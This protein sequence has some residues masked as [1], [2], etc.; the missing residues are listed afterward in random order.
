MPLGSECVVF[1]LCALST[2]NDENENGVVR[3]GVDGD[4]VSVKFRV[5]VF[6]STLL[7]FVC[8]NCLGVGP[9]SMVVFVPR[10]CC[11]PGWCWQRGYV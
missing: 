9:Y 6:V 4:G 3:T 7:V 11:R 1:G 2:G 5:F 8:L 10:V